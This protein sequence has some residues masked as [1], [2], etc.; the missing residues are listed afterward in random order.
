MSE[1]EEQDESAELV[2]PREAVRREI[3]LVQQFYRDNEPMI[4]Q[5]QEAQRF[6]REHESV[7]RQ[8]QQLQPVIQAHA[9]LRQQIEPIV[10]AAQRLIRDVQWPGTSGTFRLPVSLR[11]ALAADAGIGQLVPVARDVVVAGVP[12]MIRVEAPP[13]E[14]S[15]T[16][17]AA[18][19]PM[20][21]AGQGTVEKRPTGLAALSDGQIVFVVLVWLLAVAL[22]MLA[23]VLPP[24]A[25]AVL[26][27]SYATFAIALA[28]TS[29]I[30]DKSE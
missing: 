22:P 9:E 2:M 24:E 27:D 7:I 8:V 10:Q 16:G 15:G 30:R 13:G 28:V 29:L 4:Q 26:T 18:L 3:E 25:H 19:P 14:V 21:A 5:V 23:T 12:A 17:S 20:K 1:N 11:M 6:F